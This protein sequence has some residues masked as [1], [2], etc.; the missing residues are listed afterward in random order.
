MGDCSKCKIKKKE[1][2][3]GCDGPCH[4]WWHYSCVKFNEAEF[5]FLSKNNNVVYI[6]DSCKGNL[7]ST[8]LQNTL[9]EITHK[10]SNIP[11]DINNYIDDKL[12]MVIEKFGELLKN[13]KIEMSNLIVST[14]STGSPNTSNTTSYSRVVQ[15][16]PTVIVK[17]KN[18]KQ[19]TITTKS[20]VMRNINP[21][22]ENL[23][24]EQVKEIGGGGIAIRCEGNEKLQKLVKSKMSE[25]YD[26]K[27]VGPVYPRVRISGLSEKLDE[28]TLLHMLKSQNRSLFHKECHLK[29]ISIK[30]LRKSPSIFHATLEVDPETYINILAQVHI[31]IG[32]DYCKV[33]D[34]IE[35]RRC[36]KCCGFHHYASNCTSTSPICPKCAC[37]HTISECSSATLKCIHCSNYN[38]RQNSEE[39]Q[40]DH[41]AWDRSCFTYKLAVDNFKTNILNL[42]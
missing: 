35:I 8:N 2:L 20:E 23:D 29:F 25:T 3:I 6:C 17:P 34:A 33:Y 28:E 18:P 16:K 38:L 11:I 22:K 15:N 30:P 41:A 21:V 14:A 24:L 4:R 10:I 39:I 7:G 13:F 36:F 26:V 40:T 31:I 9:E 12:S 1:D 27:V 42:K 5:K 19:T 32:Y 37:H